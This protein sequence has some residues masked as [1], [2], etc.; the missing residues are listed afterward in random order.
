MCVHASVW[1]GLKQGAATALLWALYCSPSPP[2]RTEG[3]EGILIGFAGETGL[4][5]TGNTLEEK[6]EMQNDLDRLGS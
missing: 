2:P 4:D 1:W 3:L 5:A 6:H